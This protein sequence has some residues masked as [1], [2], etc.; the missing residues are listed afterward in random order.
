MP[1][2]R[3]TGGRLIVVCVFP[4]IFVVNAAL[5]FLYGI[6]FFV[7]PFIRMSLNGNFVFLATSLPP[8]HFFTSVSLSPFIFGFCRL[9]VV[10]PPPCIEI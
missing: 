6:M 1:R 2:E 10:A 3:H 8:I 7:C 9:V 5:L 4:F